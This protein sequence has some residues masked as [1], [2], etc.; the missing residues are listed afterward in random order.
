MEEDL[1]NRL[2]TLVRLV[3]RARALKRAEGLGD[4]SELVRLVARP[5]VPGREQIFS[6]QNPVELVQF[7]ARVGDLKPRR[8]LEIGTANGGTLYLLCRVADPSARILSVDLPGGRWGG[9][10]SRLQIPFYRRFARNQQQV[11]LIRGDSHA[12]DTVKEVQASIGP[13]EKLDVVLVDGDHSYDGVRS[14]FESYWPLLRSGGLMAFHD[15]AVTTDDQGL[16]LGVAEFWSEVKYQ[17]R[18]EEIVDESQGASFGFGLLW[19][20]EAM[21]CKE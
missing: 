21:A 1:S 12:P 19:K 17:G 9:G 4:L 6:I 16:P 2:W 15:I 13:Q 3:S 5:D 8:L 10:Y 18:F 7:I 14:D 11:V 20:S